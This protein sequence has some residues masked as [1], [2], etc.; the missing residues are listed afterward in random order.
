MVYEMAWRGEGVPADWTKPSLSQYTKG[1]LGGEG[2]WE[3]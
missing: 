2:V 3:L 1:R